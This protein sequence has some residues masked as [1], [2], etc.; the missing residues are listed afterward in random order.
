MTAPN[1][2]SHDQ[3]PERGWDAAVAEAGRLGKPAWRD[4]LVYTA[5]LHE[6]ATRP[7]AAP[8][9]HDWEE[10]GPGYLYGPAFGHWDLIHQLFDTLPTHP[11]HVR[12]QLLNNLANQKDS[13]FLPGAIWMPGGRSGR[14][15]VWWMDEHQGHPPVWVVAADEYVQ[16][17]GDTQRLKLFFAALQKQLA[18]FEAHRACVDGGF[19][20]TDVTHRLWESGIDESIRFDGLPERLK[21]SPRACVD[22]T[23][24][25]Y[26]A[27]GYAAKWAELLGEDPDDYAASAD[28]LGAFIREKLYS[29]DDGMFYDA[30][31]ID[32][33][34]LRRR[35]FDAMWPVVVGAASPEQAQRF[36][37]DVLLDDAAFFTAHPLPATAINAPQYEPRMWRGGAWNSMTHWAARGCVGYDRP[38]AAAALLER[39]LDQSAKHFDRTGTVWEFYDP[40]GGPPEAM[41]RK[42]G[43]ADL[44]RPCRDYLG[45]N[46]LLA[47]ARLYVRLTEESR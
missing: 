6:R 29:A 46:P 20:Y 17:T 39:A 24:H 31:A 1:V 23:S 34:S 36:I 15:E 14:D 16:R 4:M 8:L 22:A 13:G 41:R 43:P 47:M 18:W 40:R 42:G 21:A 28:R 3:L 19:Y 30:W 33:P 32:D 11:D 12:D 38:D 7:A 35:T 45:H 2:S 44:D 5:Q 37:D 9:P 26:E 10:I 27:Y 25:V